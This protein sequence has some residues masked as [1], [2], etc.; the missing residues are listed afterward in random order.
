M[1][2][3]KKT[4][5]FI[6]FIIILIVIAVYLNQNFT[7]FR[8]SEYHKIVL[9][10]AI[11]ILICLLVFISISLKSQLTQDWPP[12]IGDCPDYWVDTSG[13]G[14]NCVNVKNLGT[15]PSSTQ[16]QP[17]SVNFSG[18]NYSGSAGLCAKWNYANS[19]NLTWDGVTYGGASSNPCNM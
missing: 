5:L 16:G 14:G 2:S 15:C 12:V 6:A 1:S 19:C 7:F 11:I 8:I 10:I 17:L 18:P 3:F 13:N 4:L 9:I